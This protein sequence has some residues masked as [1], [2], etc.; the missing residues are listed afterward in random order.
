MNIRKIIDKWLGK[1]PV[2]KA[3]KE[4]VIK[5]RLILRPNKIKI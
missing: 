3:K 5:D 4:T 1:P 2:P